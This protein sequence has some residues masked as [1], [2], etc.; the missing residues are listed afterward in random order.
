MAHLLYDVIDWYRDTLDN[1]S[2]KNMR[3]N[4]F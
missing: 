3:H 4:K 2:G 1:R